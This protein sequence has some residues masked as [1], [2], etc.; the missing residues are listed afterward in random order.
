MS[1]EKDVLQLKQ[2]VFGNMDIYKPCSSIVVDK[3]TSPA[4]ISDNQTKAMSDGK[5]VVV[6]AGVSV[7]NDMPS[8]E[9]IKIA[10]CHFPSPLFDSVLSMHPC[11]TSGALLFRLDADGALYAYRYS[12]VGDVSGWCRGTLTALLSG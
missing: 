9:Y 3:V 5:T 10:D 4:W 8:G 7:T 1:L 12:T 6:V 2:I 11:A